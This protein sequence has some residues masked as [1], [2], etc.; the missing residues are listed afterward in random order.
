MSD[1]NERSVASGGY[2]AERP[3]G[4]PEVAV[5]ILLL[6]VAELEEAIRRLADQDATLSVVGGNVIVEMDATL[7]DAE[8]SAIRD[9]AD[10]YASLTPESAETA[11]TLRGLLERFGG[12]R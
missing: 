11:A 1:V 9:A 7:T 12:G 5:E 3:L 8:R 10:R 4:D 2:V 6:R